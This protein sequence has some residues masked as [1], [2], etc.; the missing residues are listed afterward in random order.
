MSA[1]EPRAVS[2]SVLKGGF[3]K[4]TTALNV[5]RELAH[6]NERALVVDLDDNGHMT[7]NLGFSDHY[8]GDWNYYED[9]LID[10]TDPHEA[11]VNVTDGLDLLPAHDDLESVE[12]GLKEATMGTTRLKKNVVDEL[13]G[14]DY[15]YIVVDCPANRGK[16][17]D[18]AMYATGNLIIP[19]RPENGYESG[20]SNTVNRLVMEAREHFDLDILAVVPSGLRDRIDQD[21]RDRELLKELHDR[22]A[23]RNLVPNFAHLSSEDWGAVDAGDYNGDL[24]GIR[25]RSAI[26]DAHTE[27]LPL[28]DYDESC[29]QLACYE[30][31]AEIVERGEVDR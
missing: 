17:N 5:A 27:G 29:D 18:N 14:E 24:P 4:T 12:S 6:R 16:L 13:L 3:A 1:N 23:I 2:V 21:R 8:G 28:R 9:I 31:L 25:Y 20:L 19:M 10:G 22:D 15:D 26:D 7:I 11:I 30:E